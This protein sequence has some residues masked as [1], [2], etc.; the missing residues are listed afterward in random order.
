[1]SVLVDTSVWIDYFKGLG[2][3]DKLDE[4]IDNNFVLTNDLILTEIIPVLKIKRQFRLISLLKSIERLP[5]NIDWDGL[6]NFQFQCL[7]RGINGIGIPDLIIAQNALQN[8]CMIYSHDKHFK[9]LSD[10][11]GLK[12][13]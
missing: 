7:K 10:V 3:A 11:L 4:L 6:I 8:N 5:L 2:R 1:V 13:L 12:L 9:L